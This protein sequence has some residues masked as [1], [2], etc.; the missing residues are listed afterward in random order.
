MNNFQDNEVEFEISDISYVPDLDI[1]NKEKTEIINKAIEELPEKYKVI[2]KL[3]HNEDMD[4]S[5]IA[6][7]LA[8]P[9]GTVKVNLFRARKILELTLRK[10]SEFFGSYK[11]KTTIKK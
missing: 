4:Y 10:H 9:I 1:I 6:N 5:Q 11:T 2:I 8:I 3:R 7:I